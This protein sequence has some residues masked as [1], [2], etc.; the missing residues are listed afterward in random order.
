MY[1]HD[2]VSC[3]PQAP[4]LIPRTMHGTTT[5]LPWPQFM[6]GQALSVTAVRPPSVPLALRHGHVAA[7][8]SQSLSRGS[9]LGTW[10][11]MRH[12]THVPMG[13]APSACTPSTAL[14]GH[15]V[16][17]LLSCAANRTRAFV[18]LGRDYGRGHVAAS[19]MGMR[20]VW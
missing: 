4:H 5:E 7:V 13:C 11:H 15:A 19:V 3:K 20:A 18:L 8:P 12:V 16:E 9:T 17:E 1:P 2:S 6:A 14:G 10:G